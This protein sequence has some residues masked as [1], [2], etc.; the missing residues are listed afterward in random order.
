MMM[1]GPEKVQSS[2]RSLATGFDPFL[3][4]LICF[5]NSTYDWTTVKQLG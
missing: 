2:Q 4:P 1:V 5:S 3:C